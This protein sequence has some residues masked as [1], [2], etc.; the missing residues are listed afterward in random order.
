MTKSI[1]FLFTL[2]IIGISACQNSRYYEKTVPLDNEVWTYSD[3]LDFLFNIK[4]NSAPYDL[5][6]SINHSKEYAFQNLYVKINTYFPSGAKVEDIVSLELAQ[7]GGA[8]YGDCGGKYCQLN[9]PIQQ[10]IHFKEKGD[11]KL[12]IY[13]YMRKEAIPGIKE[14]EFSIYESKPTEK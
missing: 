11:Y 13:Q 10:N 6:L 1:F 5:L 8:W 3:S 7:K 4:D 2:L 12:V 9:I 14:V